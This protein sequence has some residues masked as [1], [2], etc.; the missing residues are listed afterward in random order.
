MLGIKTQSV[1]DF[2]KKATG[3]VVGVGKKVVKVAGAV[4]GVAAAGGKNV[5]ETA[6]DVLLAQKTKA[7][8]EKVM[9]DSKEN[10]LQK[11]KAIKNVVND[12]KKEKEDRNR[13]R[14][15]SRLEKP[16]DKANRERSEA[17]AKEDEAKARKDREDASRIARQMKEGE[18]N[19]KSRNLSK[20]RE[21]CYAKSKSGKKGRMNLSTKD[22][23]KCDK[24]NN[25]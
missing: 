8:V 11:A 12:A 6:E 13:A 20:K 2:G 16:S 22:K 9:D 19:M 10:K 7:N 15:E 21:E 18:A 23:N 5:K 17:K 4:A 25:K 3:K 14:Q 1:K 24:K